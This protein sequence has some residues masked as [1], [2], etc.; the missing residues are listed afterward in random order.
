MLRNL[1]EAL[2][3]SYDAYQGLRGQLSREPLLDTPPPSLPDPSLPRA[4]ARPPRPLSPAEQA[5]AQRRAYWENKFEAVHQLRDQGLSLKAI[6]RQLNLTIHTV[7]KYS[8]LPALPK[9]TAPKPG[10][11]LI[12][13]YRD[14][15]RQRLLDGQS[16]SRPLWRELRELGFSGSHSTV[17]K[18]IVHFRQEVG[19]PAPRRPTPQPVAK[20]RPLT[21][22]ALASLVL[23]PPGELTDFQ[24]DLIVQ[25][26][27]FHPNIHSAT[28]LAREFA[29]MLRQCSVV[30]LAAWIQMVQT[31]SLPSL[32]S[33]ASGLL[34]DYDAVRAAFTF[35]WSNGQVEGQVNRL[36]VIKRIMYGRAKFDLLR[37]RV[38]HPP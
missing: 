20:H 33:F 1:W 15:L 17:Y 16:S 2:A 25:A 29:A 31:S 22:R 8:R 10:P 34:Q 35:S 5:R 36:K 38:W 3:I 4:T 12:D 28:Q 24:K 11:R 19:L 30:P 26:G 14:H 32:M 21:A 7:R 13:P 9:K 23:L 37:L 18:A 6:A 27:Q